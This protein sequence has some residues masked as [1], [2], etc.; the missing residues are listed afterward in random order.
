[1]KSRLTILLIFSFSFLIAQNVVIKGKADKSASGGWNKTLTAFAYDDYI[2]KHERELASSKVDD[3][4]KFELKFSVEKTIYIFLIVGNCRTE[5]YCEPNT[6]YE[7]GL[8]PKDSNAVQTIGNEVSAELVFY[9]GDSLEL[10]YLVTKFNELQEQFINNNIDLI[11]NK[12]PKFLPKLDTFVVHAHKKFGYIK[13]NYFQNYLNYTLASLKEKSGF[14]NRE[15]LYNKY[16]NGKP[17]LYENTEYMN[18]TDAFFNPSIAT[19]A[20]SG[21]LEKQINNV[22]N[23][24]TYLLSFSPNKYLS[25]NDTL[26]ELIALKALRDAY[27]NPAFRQGR[28]IGMLESA[29]KEC[30]ISEHKKIAANLLTELNRMRV[31]ISPPSFLLSDKNGKLVRM[32]D[33]KGRYVYLMFFT[34]WCTSCEEELLLVSNLKKKYGAKISFIAISLDDDTTAF[35]KFIEK[36]KIFDWTFLYAGNNREFKKAFSIKAIPMYYL[37]NP[38]GNVQNSPAL[39]P[40]IDLE[41]VF[42]KI[43]KPVPKNF[44][45]GEK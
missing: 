4:G 37:I 35:K 26:R 23:Y 24:E 12:S 10:N 11:Q 32:D 8:L 38:E 19:L 27:N 40:G 25:K 14:K 9:S 20:K 2:S 29:V 1:M 34:S 15:E 42:N 18:F 3:K 7:I 31:G 36:H 17:I 45:P 21:V 41:A 16:I 44:K 43:M 30:K 28:I 5:L 33:F 22:E 13:N 6:T 39:K